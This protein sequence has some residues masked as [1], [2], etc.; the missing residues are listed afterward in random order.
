[1][2]W[3]ECCSN[4]YARILGEAQNLLRSGHLTNRSCGLAVMWSKQKIHFQTGF[5]LQNLFENDVWNMTKL[6]IKNTEKIRLQRNKYLV[7]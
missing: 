1:M 2:N 4:I 6:D 3:I 7:I 5:A